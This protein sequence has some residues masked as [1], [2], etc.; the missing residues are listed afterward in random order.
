MKIAI[1]NFR[2]SDGVALVVMEGDP[3]TTH[4]IDMDD[5]L[6]V[7]DFT[8]KLKGKKKSTHKKDKFDSLDLSSLIGVDVD[9]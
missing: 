5:I 3:L 8:D 2:E 9:A 4:V 1:I 7:K 6:T